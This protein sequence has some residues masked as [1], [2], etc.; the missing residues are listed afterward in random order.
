ME[1]QSSNEF[2]TWATGFSGCD[3]GN[4]H[5]AIWFCGIEYGG[6]EDEQ[7]FCF[8]DVS[9]PA[10]LSADQLESTLAK[11]QY[12]QKVAKSYA[13][14]HG[15]EP[16]NYYQIALARKLFDEESDTFKI[17]LFPIS[18]HNDSDELWQKWLY[19]RTGLPTKSLY[20]AWCQLY[21]FPKMKQWV[22]EGNPKVIVAT[23]TSYYEIRSVGDHKP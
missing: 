5:G 6:N 21:R 20:R 10:H 9:E 4:R 2:R 13:V 14:L 19:E 12:M 7:S 17:N 23:G 15:S 11:S 8:S 16:S 22:C 18:F 1:I 3:G